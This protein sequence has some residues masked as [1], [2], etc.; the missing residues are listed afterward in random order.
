MLT[1][2]LYLF[3][4]L[5]ALFAW[6]YHTYPFPFFINGRWYWVRWYCY[7]N[8]DVAR[9]LQSQISQITASTIG[10]LLDYRIFQDVNA[11]S[12]K[13]LVVAFDFWT[14][15]PVFFNCVFR[16]DLPTEIEEKMPQGLRNTPI[17]HLGL[18]MTLPSHQGRHLQRFSILNIWLWLF[19]N[20]KTKCILTD[21]GNSSSSTRLWAD[22]LLDPFPNY[23]KWELVPKKWHTLTAHY[24]LQNY[25]IEFG[26]SLSATF[27]L[28][29][30]VVRGS[31]AKEGGGA[32]QLIKFNKTR[33]ARN[34]KVLDFYQKHLKLSAEDEVFHVAVASIPHFLFGTAA[35]QEFI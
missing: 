17:L 11:F 32:H 34:R 22:N 23:H 27:D 16:S 14:A 7:P 21:I 13:I 30:F 28:E 25:K 29:S 6:I 24:M 18:V 8:G 10:C 3:V 5:S 15:Q 4:W 1:G 26:S 19:F 2:L 31:N 20:K 33:E 9:K 35:V 12:N